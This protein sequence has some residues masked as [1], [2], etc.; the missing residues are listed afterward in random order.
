MKA[1]ILIIGC[2]R[3]GTTLLRAMLEGHPDL[4]VHPAEPQFILQGYERFG[5][6]VRDVPA[7][8]RFFSRHRYAVVDDHSWSPESNLGPEM[9]YR[10]L[11][12]GYLEAW[13]GEG[14]K[15]QRP[16]LKDPAF[17]FHLDRLN[18]LFPEAQ[19]IHILRDPRANIAS[20]L[21]RWS[22]ARL[23]ECLHWWRAAV[24]AGWRW[25]Q[26]HPE[27]YYELRYEDLVRTPVKTLQD[28]CSFLQISYTPNLLDF[29]LQL[30]QYEPGGAPRPVVYRRVQ[31]AGLNRWRRQLRPVV[32][33]I[34]E[35]ETTREMDRWG[36]D[37]L[38]AGSS[39]S[40]WQMSL[41]SLAEQGWY[42]GIRV[43]RAMKSMLR[44]G[45]WWWQYRRKTVSP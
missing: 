16:V 23:W 35:R 19:F 39:F 24:Q 12:A 27:Q 13:G 38:Q 41:R 21:A 10:D 8:V 3:S 43:L 36:Y 31:Q 26:Q 33:A 15:T 42:A 34:I 1:P 45:I 18:M 14:L 28:L 30:N 6:T 4:L 25:G 29:R 22:Q 17:I 20:Q 2:R 44:K 40:A 11:L 5:R 9:D 37:S 32:I 7:A